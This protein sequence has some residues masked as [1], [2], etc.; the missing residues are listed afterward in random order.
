[1]IQDYIDEIEQRIRPRLY[2]NFG[3]GYVLDEART[4]KDID[5][6]IKEAYNDVEQYMVIQNINGADTVLRDDP[7]G[8]GAKVLKNKW[9]KLIFLLTKSLI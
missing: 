3:K 6:R 7:G 9:K 4:F 8:K 2:L 1:M 5:K